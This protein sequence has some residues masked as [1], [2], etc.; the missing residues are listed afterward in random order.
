MSAARRL[1]AISKAILVRVLGSRKKLT[2]VFPRKAGTRSPRLMAFLKE[3]VT[4]KI[5]SISSRVRS[6]IAIRSFLCQVIRQRRNTLCTG[7]TERKPGIG[8]SSCTVISLPSV[9]NPAIVV[10]VVRGKTDSAR[11]SC[12]YSGATAFGFL[13]N[14]ACGT[15]FHVFSGQCQVK[16]MREKTAFCGRLHSVVGK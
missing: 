15:V 5:V 4:R 11:R 8:R 3:A 7:A 13:R 9:A 6:S 10:N 16:A 2:T 14:L 1:A 12:R